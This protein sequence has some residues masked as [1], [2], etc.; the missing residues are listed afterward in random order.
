MKCPKCGYTSFDYLETCKKCGTDLSDIRA[1]LGVIA[2][3]PDERA[4]SRPPGV[5]ASIAALPAAEPAA[6]GGASFLTQE[7]TGASFDESFED[8]VQPTR[9]GDDDIPTPATP[10]A[11]AVDAESAAAEPE[12]E[13]LD[14]DFGGIFEDENKK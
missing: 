2:V 1:L 7:D 14:L 10:K 11:R 9:L 5:T 3:P 4:I 12:E 6:F 13:F 8:L